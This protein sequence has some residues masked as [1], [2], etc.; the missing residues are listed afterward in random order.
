MP[1]QMLA[2]IFV[3]EA[4]CHWCGRRI[5]SMLICFMFIKGFNLDSDNENL[6]ENKDFS[7]LLVSRSSESPRL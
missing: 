1:F 4:L 5:G 6:P 2:C 7:A 3:L